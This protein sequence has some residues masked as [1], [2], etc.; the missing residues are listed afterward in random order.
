M[1]DLIML[2]E[3][4]L[5]DVYNIKIERV[6]FDYMVALCKFKI[7]NGWL[8]KWVLNNKKVVVI[9]KVKFFESKREKRVY[10]TFC[11]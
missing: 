6:M 8:K 5:R 3:D 10:A 2:R 11:L 7:F 4:R 9:E 1:I